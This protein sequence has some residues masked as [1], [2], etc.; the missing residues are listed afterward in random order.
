[1]QHSN[2]SPRSSRHPWR[3]IIATEHLRN[4]WMLDIDD[5]EPITAQGSQDT[6]AFLRSKDCSKC[7]IHIHK[8]IDFNGK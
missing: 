2:S 1:M 3:R 6:L 4:S 8:C 7:D 5:D